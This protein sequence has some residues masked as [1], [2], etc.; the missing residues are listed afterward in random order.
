[1]SDESIIP[2]KLGEVRALLARHKYDQEADARQEAEDVAGVE[3]LCVL[4]H[5]DRGVD[6]GDGIG[7]RGELGP[8]D[9]GHAVHDLT[10]QIGELHDIRVGDPDRPWLRVSTGAGRKVM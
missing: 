2:E 8:A 7:D 1:M 9:V 5:P 4:D 6:G 3:P 10:V